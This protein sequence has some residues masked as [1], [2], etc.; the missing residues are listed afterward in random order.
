MQNTT[1][2]WECQH[3]MHRTIKINKNSSKNKLAKIGKLDVI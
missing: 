1:M 2:R 3:A